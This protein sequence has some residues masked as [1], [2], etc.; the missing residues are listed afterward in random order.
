MTDFVKYP[1]E[2]FTIADEGSRRQ[3]LAT[4]DAYVFLFGTVLYELFSDRKV[5]ETNHF[6]HL[7]RPEIQKLVNDCWC[8]VNKRTDF[9]KIIRN[10]EISKQLVLAEKAKVKLN[11]ASSSTQASSPTSLHVDNKL[12]VCAGLC[13]D[14]ETSS[15][16]LPLPMAD[17]TSNAVNAAP[18][19]S[20]QNSSINYNTDIA[21]SNQALAVENVFVQNQ[22]MRDALA[23]SPA[24]ALLQVIQPC[25]LFVN[26]QHPCTYTMANCSKFDGGNSVTASSAR[27]SA[28]SLKR[29][30]FDSSPA[31]AFKPTPPLRSFQ[32]NN[33]VRKK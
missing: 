24:D 23:D 32:Y 3:Y 18:H 20:Y 1:S 22:Q 27:S 7:L 19:Q 10:L 5:A 29:V 17:I 9:D 6:F 12:I 26:Q 15:Q 16:T 11:A 4:E 28:R 8:K 33:T 14:D 21:P 13:L 25:S 31:M 30:T 2:Y